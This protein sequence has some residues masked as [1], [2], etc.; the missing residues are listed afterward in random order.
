MVIICTLILCTA[1]LSSCTL[2]A[3]N[4]LTSMLI[5]LRSQHKEFCSFVSPTCCRQASNQ[6]KEFFSIVHPMCCRQPVVW[7]LAISR[8]NLAVLL[9]WY[10]AGKHTHVHK[11]TASEQYP[12]T[13]CS[14]KPLPQNSAPATGSSRKPPPQN[15]VPATGCSRKPL[16]QTNVLATGCSRNPPPQNNVLATGV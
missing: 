2:T 3:E 9:F 14:R 7:H 11:W 5:T 10:P 12:A 4:T 13:G 15:S 16:P 6:H 1:Q 8:R